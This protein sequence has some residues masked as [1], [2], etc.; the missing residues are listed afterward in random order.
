[1]KYNRSMP[2]IIE[3]AKSGRPMCKGACKE[4][5]DK[6]DLRLGSIFDVGSY[7]STS[8]RC[9]NCVTAK[10]L[11]NIKQAAI[12]NETVQE[13]DKLNYSVIPGFDNL[14]TKDKKI[15]TKTFDSILGGK[16]TKKEKKNV[17]LAKKPAAKTKKVAPAKKPAVKTKKVVKPVT[18]PA[19]RK[20]RTMIVK[21]A[22]ADKTKK[23]VKVKKPAAKTKKA[24]KVKQPAVKT[25]AASK[26]G[27]PVT[28]KTPPKAK[29]TAKAAPKIG[30]LATLKTPPKAE[31]SKIVTPKKGAPKTPTKAK[32]SKKV[33][34]SA[35]KVPKT[36]KVKSRAGRVVTPTTRPDFV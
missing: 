1:M 9:L 28:P 13:S 23:A 11:T 24:V 4:P 18:P 30:R 5:I 3:P 36:P 2:Y 22:P 33:Q 25:K 17:A 10:Q 16:S 26:K 8:W 35:K 15:A 12:L 19:G 21:K 27:R 20:P 7:N 34:S 31:T 14:S 32:A 29:E 6:G